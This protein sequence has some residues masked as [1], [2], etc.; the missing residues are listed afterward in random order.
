MKKCIYF[1]V[2]FKIFF[3][4]TSCSNKSEKMSIIDNKNFYIQQLESQSVSIEWDIADDNKSYYAL[5]WD[6]E[7]YYSLLKKYTEKPFPKNAA[8]DSILTEFTL[9]SQI[10]DSNIAKFENLEPQKKYYFTVV[11]E[12]PD[13]HIFGIYSKLLLIE[14]PPLPE[15]D[16]INIVSK[17]GT[18]VLVG[19]NEE[20][21]VIKTRIYWSPRIGVVGWTKNGLFAYRK[22]DNYQQENG[23]KLVII[24]A[25]E[26]KII[27]EEKI[28]TSWEGWKENSK[29][30]IE[31]GLKKWN[32]L[33]KIYGFQEEIKEVFSQTNFVKPMQFPMSENDKTYDCW[34]DSVIEERDDYWTTKWNLIVSNEEM[35]KV[36]ASGEEKTYGFDHENSYLGSAVIGYFLSPY[37]NRII[38]LIM[39]FDAGKPDM[40]GWEINTRINY[41]GCHLNIG[42]R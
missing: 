18:L 27:E 15:K 26:D 33:L 20:N 4:I 19:D 23:V 28:I 24:N 36:I 6:S 35:K 39:H 25:I 31:D 3:I 42:F 8:I 11:S 7:L 16:P 21:P 40:I 22:I 10:T 9:F 17:R 12:T 37:E 14:T 30:E 1:F 29:E 38:V 32:E 34:I 41:Y 2:L 5:L 13:K